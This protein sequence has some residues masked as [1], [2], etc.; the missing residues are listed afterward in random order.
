MLKKTTVMNHINVPAV[1]MH[2]DIMDRFFGMDNLGSN[3]TRSKM[4]N[5][6]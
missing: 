2:K 1:A 5:M 3:N 6:L 4:K